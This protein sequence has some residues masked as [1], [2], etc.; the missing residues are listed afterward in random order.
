[1]GYTQQQVEQLMEKARVSREEAQ[2]ALERSGGDLLDALLD[3]ERQ[4]KIPGDVP[5]GGSYTTRPAGG[6]EVA[7]QLQAVSSAGG[8]RTGER[9][10][11][12]RD[13]LEDLLGELGALF[14]KA[15]ENRFE[16]W[17]HGTRRMAMPVL[18]LIL[19]VVLAF[20]ISVPLLLLGL[21]LGYRY[22]FAGPDLDEE[23]LGQAFDQAARRAGET[24]HQVKNQVKRA[25][26]RRG[27]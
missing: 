20:Y 8:R 26:G 14:R 7:G 21:I 12:G 24:A 11:E 16:V 15:V 2:A 18:I 4:G 6:D 9:R 10:D 3:L 1:M 17:R 27:K 22:R 19:M 25:W 5:H 23:K 13:R